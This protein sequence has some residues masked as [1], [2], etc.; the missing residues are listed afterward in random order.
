M[1]ITHAGL[2]SCLSYSDV[3]IA[4]KFVRVKELCGNGV[5]IEDPSFEGID[6]LEDVSNQGRRQNEM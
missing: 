2:A 3:D 5:T 4:C 6:G 1:L